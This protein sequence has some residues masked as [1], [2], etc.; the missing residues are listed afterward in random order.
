MAWAITL[1]LGH[2]AAHDASAAEP[3]RPLRLDVEGGALVAGS[4]V[5]VSIGSTDVSLDTDAGP[6][7]SVGVGYAVIDQLEV[8]AAFHAASTDGDFFDSDVDYIGLT[9]GLRYYPLG[10]AVMVR[11]W[12]T[13]AGGWYHAEADL[14]YIS[15]FGPVD[16]DRTDDGGGVN[17]GGG[18][19]VPIGRR[20]SVGGDLRYHR[21]FGVFDDPG[22]LTTMVNVAVYFGELRGPC[23]G[24]APARGGSPR[25][26]PGPGDEAATAH[27]VRGTIR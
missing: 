12:L 23:Q 10:R 13:A 6:A 8:G 7:L 27:P 1:L 26:R 2:V 20:V 16:D 15:L 9:A 5:D 3:T 19:D 17:V 11:P 21:T 25:S 18:L 14:N 22:F 4:D 24:V